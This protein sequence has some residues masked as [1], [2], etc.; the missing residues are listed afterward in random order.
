MSK[1]IDII[2]LLCGEQ[3][4]AHQLVKHRNDMLSENVGFCKT[5]VKNTVATDDT[6]SVKDMLRILNIPYVNDVWE[7][8]IEKESDNMFGRYLQ[9][10]ATKKKFKNF[11]DS[12]REKTESVLGDF[13]ITDDM[14][15]R[16]GA[17]KAK[18]DYYVME[19]AYNALRRIKEPATTLEETRYVQ[20]VML[21][22]TLDEALRSGDHKAITPLKKTYGAD[23]KELGLDV[24]AMSKE[25]T[26]TLGTRIQE[27]E[28]NAPIPEISSEF[29]DV[30]GIKAYVNKYF[31]IP[32]KRVFGQATEDEVS[33]LYD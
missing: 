19:M 20:N 23:L 10:I 8:A 21:K 30:D 26:R 3:K 12:D 6:E 17:G 24:D 13:E 32:M 18:D 1:K 2:C 27:W 22:T 29:E 16:W 9:L 15:A 33:S 31:V 4:T 7:N 25:D 5:C 28:R 11:A 14:I